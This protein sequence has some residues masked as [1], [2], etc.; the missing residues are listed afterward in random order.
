MPIAVYPPSHRDTRAPQPEV[1]DLCGLSVPAHQLVESDCEGLRGLHVCPFC[2]HAMPDR[3]SHHEPR[4]LNPID[5]DV[6][7]TGRVYPPGATQEFWNPAAEL[8]SPAH[9]ARPALWLRNFSI[10]TDEVVTR[11]PGGL[12]YSPGVTLA[13]GFPEPM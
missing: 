3:L 10:P 2:H 4:R 12:A 7:G 8:F 13:T 9:I 1:C 5:Y 11:W 6:I